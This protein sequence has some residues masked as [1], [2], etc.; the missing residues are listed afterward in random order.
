MHTHD[1]GAGND[2]VLWGCVLP[3]LL[4]RVHVDDVYPAM[5]SDANER[6]AVMVAGLSDCCN[7]GG[8]WG[9]ASSVEAM[10]WVP[11]IAGL[12][13]LG[14]MGA[15][16]YVRLVPSRHHQ[17]VPHSGMVNEVVQLLACQGKIDQGFWRQSFQNQVDLLPQDGKSIVHLCRVIAV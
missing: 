2:G 7:G 16:G 14:W 10:R 3:A 9:D 6:A 15:Q 5:A 13:Q 1:I 4:A 17:R 11:S 12:P 8:R